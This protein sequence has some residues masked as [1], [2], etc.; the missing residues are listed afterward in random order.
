MFI[1]KHS[2]ACA[3]VANGLLDALQDEVDPG[4]K[5]KLDGLRPASKPAAA[6]REAPDASCSITC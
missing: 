4:L 5:K 6:L 3:D 2:F 1:L